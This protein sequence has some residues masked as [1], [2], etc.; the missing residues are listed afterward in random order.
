MCDTQRTTPVN[1]DENQS[2]TK[3]I[4]KYASG[5][6]YDSQGQVASSTAIKQIR[7]SERRQCNTSSGHSGTRL[8]LIENGLK[9]AAGG[10]SYV[11]TPVTPIRNIFKGKGDGE[12]KG[13]G[14]IGRNIR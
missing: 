11:D 12:E 2:R 13:E 9:L 10:H 8:L 5:I 4:S 7:G 6:I 1:S 14:R 3:S